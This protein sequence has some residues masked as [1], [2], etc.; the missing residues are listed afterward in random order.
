[1]SK[2]WISTYH[3]FGVLG[4]VLIIF[5]ILRILPSVLFWFFWWWLLH[6]EPD[7]EVL[8]KCILSKNCIS[9]LQAISI[10]VVRADVLCLQNEWLRRWRFF[11]QI[12]LRLDMGSLNQVEFNFPN[13]YLVR[14]GVFYGQREIYVVPTPQ[15][16]WFVVFTIQRRLILLRQEPV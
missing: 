6:C 4:V 16:M 13:D 5:I 10:S 7:Q 2:N 3:F 1:M 9:E 8:I 14:Q 11:N 12:E 15:N